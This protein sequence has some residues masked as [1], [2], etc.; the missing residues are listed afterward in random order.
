M[1]TFTVYEAIHCLFL[2][3][4]MQWAHELGLASSPEVRVPL[5]PVAQQ[6]LMTKPVKNQALDGQGPCEYIVSMLFACKRMSFYQFRF[7]GL[8]KDTCM[9]EVDLH[10]YIYK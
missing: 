10:A 1:Y 9:C 6:Y 8:L 3:P 5:Y 2:F 4:M 7:I